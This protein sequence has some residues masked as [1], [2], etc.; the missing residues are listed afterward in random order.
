MSNLYF[1]PP[2]RIL[3]MDDDVQLRTMM[4]L[5]LSGEGYAVSHANDEGTAVSLHRLDP[6][7]L[8]IIELGMDGTDAFKTLMELRRHHDPTRFI[9]TTKMNLPLAEL[10][11]TMAQQLGAHCVLRKPFE[12]EKL[13]ATVREA[14]E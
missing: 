11:G 14:L 1:F 10:C 13:L 12:P 8:V 2:P 7:D 6:F 5:M 9:A 4:G 3:I